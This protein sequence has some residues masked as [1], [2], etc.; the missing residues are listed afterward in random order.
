MDAAAVQPV[1]SA[2]GL[3][4]MR[5]RPP[6]APGRGQACPAPLKAQQPPV[7]STSRRPLQP[8]SLLLVAALLNS[9]ICTAAG[10]QPA[11]SRTAQRSSRS[12]L[13]AERFAKPPIVPP[14]KVSVLASN[15]PAPARMVTASTQLASQALTQQKVRLPLPLL[16]TVTPYQVTSSTASRGASILQG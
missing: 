7:S 8:A 15:A 5:N 11:E 3:I 14:P 10:L 12:L 9:L 2:R 4:D 6:H 13:G 1:W 16:R